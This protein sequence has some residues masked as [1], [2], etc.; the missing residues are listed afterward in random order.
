[1]KEVFI[2]RYLWEQFTNS[3]T[4]IKALI[5]T[6]IAIW[7]V[8]LMAVGVALFFFWERP[9]VAQPPTPKAL[10]TNPA[11]QLEPT[12]GLINTV[13]AINGQGWTPGSTIFVHLTSP[14][15]AEGS[16]FGGNG[17]ALNSVV[18]DAGGQFTVTIPIVEEPRWEI[19][20][21]VRVIARTEGNEARAQAF[22]SLVGEAEQPTTTPTA[23][24]EPPAEPTATST[25]TPTDTP[26]PGEP[27]LTTTVD[28]N[29]RS[30]PGLNY[31]LLGLLRVNQSA[32]VIG[33]SPDG[34]WWQISFP[35]G[36]DGRGWVAAQYVVAKNTDNVPIVR[37]D[38]AAPTATPGPTA[39]PIIITD[40]RGEYYDNA[41]MSGSP[42]L[43]RNDAA[44]NFDWGKGAPAAGLPADNFAAR[45]TRN[46]YFASG[47]YRFIVRAD[48]GV[49]LWVDDRLLI[50]QWHDSSATVYTADITLSEGQHSLKMA[51]YERVGDAVAQ[52]T[53]ERLNSYP[54]W[55][56]EYY[57]NRN[58]NGA[59]ILVRND[60][61][62]NFYWG[63]GAPGPGLPVD[64]FS[65]RWSRNA[66]FRA[67]SYRFTIRVDDGARFWVDN[68]LVIDQ[69]R[70][71]AATTYTAEM[72][73]SEGDHNL[74]LEYYERGNDALIQL[75]WER[76]DNFP[77]WKAEYFNNRRLQDNPV[78][79]RNETKIDHDWGDGS[80]ANELPVDNFSARWTRR[81]DF[82][83]GTYLFQ[84]KVDDGARLWLDDSLVIDSWQ[85][86]SV[87]LLA[88]KRQVSKGQHRL[89]VEY[90]ERTGGAQIEVRWERYVE[91][92]N[93]LPLPA[94]GG[95]YSLNEGGQV[96]FD[97]RGSKDPDGTI[98]TYEW[99]FNYDG[100]TFHNE[101]TGPIV[102]RQYP[103]GPA[104]VV[105]ALRVTDN[106]G[107]SQ[108]GT[109][110][111]TVLNVA[112][113]VEAGGPYTGQAGQVITLAG[114]A[115]DAG[116]IDQTG[117]SYRWDFGDGSIGNGPI[118]SHSFGGAGSYT[119][120]LTVTDKDGGQ[121]SDTATVQVSRL[122]QAPQAVISGPDKGMAGESLNF[123][124]SGSSDSDGSIVSY[125]WQFG[126]GATAS[127]VEVSHT[128]AAAERYTVQLTVTDNEGLTAT[129]SKVVEIDQIIEINLPPTAVLTGPTN[130]RAGESLS[131]SGSGSSDSDG[132]IVS[133]SWD[134]GD[135]NMGEGPDVSHTFIAPGSYKVTLTVVDDD[136]SPETA[137]QIIQ[138]DPSDTPTP[139]VEIS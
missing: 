24:T 102:S 97:G 3:S 74:R 28:L 98:T 95:P 131:F 90:Y 23:T 16:G 43:I 68:K 119:V 136:G 75:A 69:W 80:P 29:V 30:G 4:L 36:G 50:D 91:H 138:I 63:Q 54:D 113:L 64:N 10:V 13:V 94:P 121:G 32:P 41:T 26:Q 18:V 129:A 72:N 6:I 65:V 92:S 17:F 78:L 134:F 70:D 33:V 45:W 100:R 57:D 49:L 27:L 35:G 81:A 19:P 37:P 99:D 115:T 44:I 20:G 105:V 87:R 139:E 39:T 55:K 137:S 106:A 62:V 117:L 67:G 60:P 7:V 11:I 109:T 40:W 107:A 22:F 79:V 42:K 73:L 93:E 112:P 25:P 83:E 71:S 66:Y 126:D 85:D 111:V 116:L 5:M 46:L 51:Y 130:G 12:A 59:P 76:M 120:K 77:D 114:T 89:E 84:V 96:V 101:A 132:I 125:V 47:A 122:N 88:A 8:A 58:L 53:W 38:S 34:R 15:E 123:S 9:V 128:Y 108:I 82:Q 86:G 61:V 127:G 21:L 2:M 135:G 52:L 118:V 48:D 1:M 103:D 124:G 133:Y 56:G 104:T 14:Y 110:Q 31:A